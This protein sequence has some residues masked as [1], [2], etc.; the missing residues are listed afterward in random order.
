M[1]VC[2]RYPIWNSESSSGEHVAFEVNWKEQD[3]I[4]IVR[5]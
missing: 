1:C 3:K 2:L 4:V 5:D